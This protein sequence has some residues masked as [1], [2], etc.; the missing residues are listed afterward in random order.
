M[1]IDP[2]AEV[3]ASTREFGHPVNLLLHPEQNVD[4]TRVR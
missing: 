1:G 2:I 4:Q 3:S